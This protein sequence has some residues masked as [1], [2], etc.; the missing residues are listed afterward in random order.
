MAKDIL[1]A[2]YGCLIG[3][4]IGDALGAPVEGWY[5]TDI[6]AK[7]GRVTELMPGFGN[8]GACYGGTTGERYGAAYDGPPSQP[9]WITDDTTM[10]HYLSLAI[11]RKQ[12]RVTP[13]DYRDVL[14]ELFNPNRVWVNERALIWKL[15]AGVN[16]WDSGRGQIPAGCATMMI[17]PVGIIN[18]GNPA[19]AYQDGWNIAYV[20]QEG[21]NR[22]GAATVAAGVAAAF[23]PDATVETVLATMTKYSSE[24]M[25]RAIE[26][27]MDLATT[28]DSVDDFAEKYY[29][30]MLDW[31]WPSPPGHAWNKD[32]FFSGNTVE[33]VPITMAILHLCDGDVNESIIE[34]ASFGRD[35]DTTASLAGSIAGVMHGASALR[36]D[37]IETVEQANVDFFVEVEGDPRANFLA[38]ARRLVSALEAEHRTAEARARLLQTLLLQMLLRPSE[39]DEL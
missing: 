9:G 35:C 39:E 6:R 22:D 16:P 37:W 29:A 18:A 31:S 8:T 2:V 28:S 23:L 14:V 34:A 7:H 26:L 24:F 38:M 32:R 30:K 3:G 13:D 33:L 5:W 20:D 1:D 4:A 10:R 27:T 25:R 21:H 15:K 19:Q 36:R 17:A 12:G 11:A